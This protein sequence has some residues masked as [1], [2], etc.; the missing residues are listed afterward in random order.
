MAGDHFSDVS[1]SIS[2]DDHLD[3]LL[4]NK[5]FLDILKNNQTLLNGLKDYRLKR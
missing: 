3:V 5:H 1:A 2:V 4:G